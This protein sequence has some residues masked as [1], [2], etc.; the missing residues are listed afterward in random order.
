M[1]SFKERPI[2][3]NP[4]HSV[5][6]IDGD[7]VDGKLLLSSH[8]LAQDRRPLGHHEDIYCCTCGGWRFA[9]RILVPYLPVVN[10][11]FRREL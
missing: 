5:E 9:Q 11:G 7:T 3:P 2:S 10:T 4:H 1:I 8:Q 6:T